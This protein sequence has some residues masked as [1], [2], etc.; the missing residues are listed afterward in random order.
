MQ[1][2]IAK[3]IIQAT[4]GRLGAAIYLLVPLAGFAAG[5]NHFIHGD[6]ERAGP[7][8]N[9]WD[10]VDKSN[11]LLVHSRAESIIVEGATAT[12]TAFPCSPNFVDLDG[13]G[14]KDLVVGDAGGFVWWF[15]NFGAKGKPAFRTGQFVP[16]FFGTAC[17]LHV[18]DWDSDGKLDLVTGN[19]EGNVHV[20][21]N[22]GTR[23]E[24]KFTTVMSKPRIGM[25]NYANDTLDATPLRYGK[26]ALLIGNYAAPWVSDWNG[27]GRPDLLVGEGTYSANSV[28]IFLNSGSAQNPIF[29][30][31]GKY[32]LA[33][34]EGKEQLTPIVCDWDGDGVADLL[35]GER[36]GR[37]GFFKGKK[38][39]GG[40]TVAAMQGKAAPTVL[41]FTEY[42]PVGGPTNTFI[43]P[44]VC[45]Y[46]CD[47]NEDGL[48]DLLFGRNDGRVLIALNTGSKGKPVIGKPTLLTGVD[49]EKDS[50][51]AAGWGYAYSRYSNSSFLAE[52]LESD[53]GAGGEQI[54]PKSGKRLLKWSYL[55]GYPGYNMFWEASPDWGWGLDNWLPHT[56][57]IGGKWLRTTTAALTIG[58]TYTLSFWYRGQDIRV[59]WFLGMVEAI[60][61]PAKRGTGSWEVHKVDG[62]VAAGPSW[63]RFTRTFMIPGS[64]DSRGQSMPFWFYLQMVGAGKVYFDDFQLTGPQ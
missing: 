10:G 64:K 20:I 47:W 57:E 19:S 1:L 52:A 18:C 12:S 36:E 17:K 30:E 50:Q 28:W 21:L 7:L 60:E 5:T 40:S 38:R 22:I 61:N 24:P 2:P 16:T 27:D 9:N 11:L 41:D 33:Y 35:A 32:P 13:D 37:L 15:K 29:D 54:K 42:I 53:A 39:A 6:F 14:L 26:R 4:V 8:V 56:W 23:N 46:P 3:R 25:F 45:A 31:G 44:M 51:Y 62:Q 55:H 43:Q 48:L 49:T 59:N 58:K 63:Q 34:G